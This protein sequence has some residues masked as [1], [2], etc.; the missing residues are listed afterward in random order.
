MQQFGDAPL[1]C[2]VLVLRL[3]KGGLDESGVNASIHVGPRVLG[4][5]VL[6]YG[7]VC[8]L[9]FASSNSKEATSRNERP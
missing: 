8:D 6:G 1:G 3:N 9:P 7:V 4:D 5:L 2:V